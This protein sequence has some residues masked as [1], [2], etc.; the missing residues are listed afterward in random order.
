M[1]F[2]D[3]AEE[4]AFRQQAYTWL[5][6]HATLKSGI[7]EASA[8]TDAFSDAEVAH[9]KASK[10]F[11]KAERLYADSQFLVAGIRVVR[12]STSQGR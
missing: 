8:M 2:D 3:T 1:D 6:E 9:V 5:S 11:F 7:T 12:G 4:A 10:E